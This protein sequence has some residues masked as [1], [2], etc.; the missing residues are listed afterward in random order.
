[1]TASVPKMIFLFFMDC[2]FKPLLKIARIV[3]QRIV[4]DGVWAK[5]WLKMSIKKPA[6]RVRVSNYLKFDIISGDWLEVGC[7]LLAKTARCYWYLLPVYWSWQ[8]P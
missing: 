4:C 7:R 5:N 1:M 6:H 2:G 8:A 3:P